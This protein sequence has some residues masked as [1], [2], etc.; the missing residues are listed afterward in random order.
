M[1]SFG[2]SRDPEIPM[3]RMALATSHPADRRT[4]PRRR[5]AGQRPAIGQRKHAERRANRSFSPYDHVC[6][7]QEDRDRRC[8]TRCFSSPSQQGALACREPA[9]A[10][11]LRAYLEHM[12]TSDLRQIDEIVRSRPGRDQAR[13]GARRLQRE[14]LRKVEL[15]GA[16]GCGLVGGPILSRHGSAPGFDRPGRDQPGG[17]RRGRTRMRTVVVAA[18]Q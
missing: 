4:P 18:I 1:R 11:A 7:G 13:S 17:Y 5:G 10:D 9:V 14:A 6:L 8:S 15:L 3:L 12:T 2:R 16:A